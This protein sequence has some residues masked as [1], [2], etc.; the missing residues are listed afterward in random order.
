MSN[1]EYTPLGSIA[2]KTSFFVLGLTNTAILQRCFWANNLLS[3]SINAFGASLGFIEYKPNVQADNSIPKQTWSIV[4]PKVDQ[5]R[6]RHE[7]RWLLSHYRT[8]SC[9]ANGDCD[10]PTENCR[11]PIYELVLGQQISPSLEMTSLEPI[12]TDQE[13]LWKPVQSIHTS[14]ILNHLD[15]RFRRL[16]TQDHPMSVETS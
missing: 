13:A 1:Y 6:L 15:K 7:R 3:R 11:I 14:T 8:M 2:A 16:Q 4:L 10:Q 12:F 9:I 5:P